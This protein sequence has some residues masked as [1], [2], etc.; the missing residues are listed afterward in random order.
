MAIIT[1]TL[2]DVVVV[3]GTPAH[4]P[5]D[6]R[7]RIGN[8]LIDLANYGL[9][10]TYFS[11]TL[12]SNRQVTPT[13]DRMIFIYA[14]GPLPLRVVVGGII[15]SNYCGANEQIIY[16]N[17]LIT[18]D[19]LSDYAVHNTVQPIRIFVKDLY[20][21]AFLDQVRVEYRDPASRIGGFLLLFTG[22]PSED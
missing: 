10:P 19:R 20:V 8:E 14:F 17:P 18:L 16:G 3:D 13:L 21:D 6:I 15:L 7:F 11:N 22:V 2:T 5:L 4:S 1:S 9:I 12:S